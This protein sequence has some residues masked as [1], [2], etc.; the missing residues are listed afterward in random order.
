ME[1]SESSVVIE[2]SDGFGCELMFEHAN[3]S[4]AE[5]FPE[6]PVPDGSDTKLFPEKVNS[7]RA[8]KLPGSSKPESLFTGEGSQ[9][10]NDSGK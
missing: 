5:Q 1:G 9:I 3:S 8:E 10:A 2:G 6:S 7:L 4:R